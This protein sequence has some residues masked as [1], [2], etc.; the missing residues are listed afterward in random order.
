MAPPGANYSG[1]RD[2]GSLQPA[3]TFHQYSIDQGTKMWRQK[4]ED[5]M[6]DKK[7]NTK[8]HAIVHGGLPPHLLRQSE[9]SNSS[10][11]ARASAYHQGQNPTQ[12]RPSQASGLRHHLEKPALSPKPG[13]KTFVHQQECRPQQIPTPPQTHAGPPVAQA[14]SSS[15]LAPQRHQYPP[16]PTY[17]M[18]KRQQTVYMAARQAPGTHP[19]L[20]G[21][22]SSRWYK[23]IPQ[24]QDS[25]SPRQETLGLQ[26]ESRSTQQEPFASHKIPFCTARDEGVRLSVSSYR[27]GQTPSKQMAAVEQTHDNTVPLQKKW[28]PKH[29]A[30]LQ[31][32]SLP[33]VVSSVEL[34]DEEASVWRLG[35][36]DEAVGSDIRG[37]IAGNLDLARKH[38]GTGFYNKNKWAKDASEDGED[39]D[40]VAWLPSS[41]QDWINSLP[42]KPPPVAWC[43]N[44]NIERSEECDLQ[45]LNGF[46]M[47]PVDYPDTHINPAD[48]GDPGQMARRLSVSAKLKAA[49]DYERNKRRFESS[50]RKLREHELLN[51]P[52]YWRPIDDPLPPS[53]P[54]P[55]TQSMGGDGQVY[56]GSRADV[57][58]TGTNGM[59]SEAINGAIA[60][61]INQQY[62]WQSYVKISCFLR[63]VEQGDLAQVLEIY[64][65]EVVNGIQA[66]DTKPLSL[67]DMQRIFVQCKSAQTPF[68]V[69]IAGTPAEA[70]VRKEVPASPRVPYKAYSQG[71]THQSQKPEQD[72]VLGFGFVF[73]AST[74]IAGGVNHNVARFQGRAHFY[75][76]NE[77][78]RNGIGRALMTRLAQCCSV[79]TI[80][81]DD[82][83]WYDPGRNP[84]CDVVAFNARNYSRL[85]IETASRGKTDP[86]T[87]WLAKLLDSEHFLCISTMDNA[88]KT[89]S[90]MDG[91]WL[92][93]LVWQ[94]DCQDPKMVRENVKKYT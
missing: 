39:P 94:L 78:R 51:P 80:G 24:V 87:V 86:D 38:S 3:S 77:S 70:A 28:R 56:L 19:A 58:H 72:K 68:I 5:D 11:H 93:N 76:A 45:P 81:T 41:C 21:I 91:T 49:A 73:I 52:S 7:E 35:S 37:K 83:E 63:P 16:T 64:N 17:E 18:P 30:D 46:L 84:A 60:Q 14:S 74:G 89:G 25:C 75:V 9:P 62:E 67:Q 44:Q 88:R 13:M 42:N 47:A 2:G 1:S 22:M 29:S 69:A 34:N 61:S 27:C 10:C 12:P 15:N 55:P 59:V 71:P 48:I 85:F 23:E 66:L 4:L 53:Q 40:A 32:Q 54:K 20:K 92:D 57:G 31:S 79:Y 8:A 6:K 26:R 65:W 82:C 90:G 36:D 33:S 50:E 43:I